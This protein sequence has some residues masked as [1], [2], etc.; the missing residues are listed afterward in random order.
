ML[1]P[2]IGTMRERD[3]ENEMENGGPWQG[4]K[5]EKKGWQKEKERGRWIEREGEGEVTR[6]ERRSAASVH[7]VPL[8]VAPFLEQPFGPQYYSRGLVHS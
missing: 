4:I 3:G 1:G 7:V 2:S 8:F 6:H 5:E